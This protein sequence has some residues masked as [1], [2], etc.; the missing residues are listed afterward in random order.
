MDALTTA[1][2][3]AY[4]AAR[5]VTVHGQ[6]PTAR[7]VMNWCRNKALKATFRGAGTRG[8]YEIETADLDTFQPPRMGRRWTKERD[9][10]KE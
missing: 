3:A 10:A 5:G 4:L 9:D 1:E 7:H 2:A 8:V 6:P